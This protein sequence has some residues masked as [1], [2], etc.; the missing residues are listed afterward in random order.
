MKTTVQ[1]EGV[2]L[3]VDGLTVV[4]DGVT[5]VSDVSFEIKPGEWLGLIGPNG[6]GKS[7][8]LR[9][10]AG[11]TDH[12]GTV[13]LSTTDFGDAVSPA[14]PPTATDVAI[15]PQSPVLPPGMTVIE[16]VLLGR[17]AHLGWLGRE[18]SGDRQ[19]AARMLRE[20]DLESFATRP[21]TQLSGGEAQRTVLARALAQ[22]PTVLLLDEP[23]SAL[24]IGHQQSVLELVDRLRRNTGL[25]VL[26]A[27]H[28][29]TLAARFSDRLALITAGRIDTVGQPE[30]VLTD[31]L[32]SGAYG[33]PLTV[34][35][36]NTEAPSGGQSD[37]E[38]NVQS[39]I[40][41]DTQSDIQSD[42]V[43]LPAYGAR[44]NR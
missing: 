30:D 2:S 19:V 37:S 14:G 40:Q 8:V 6:A 22:E 18:S 42:I 25:A 34:A 27:M 41:S 35:R 12:N 31:E 16:Y 28:D 4:A 38:P 3:I 26:A 10:I 11:I 21:V 7:T 13:S 43:V 44:H 17:T 23:T 15:V 20:L 39:D 29:L 36:L 9:A 33:V 5:L 32:L 24:D 1:S